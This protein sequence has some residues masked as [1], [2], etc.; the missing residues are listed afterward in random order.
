MERL[1]YLVVTLFSLSVS[2]AIA[3]D[4]IVPK[5]VTVLTEEQL[6]NKVVGNTFYNY[7]WDEYYEPGIE[8]KLEGKLTIKHRKYGLVSGAWSIKGSQFC[9]NYDKLPLSHHGDCFTFAMDGDK[10]TY[11]K[12]DGSIWHSK[13]GTIKQKMG[14]PNNF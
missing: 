14:N 12:A 7:N 1:S 10:V 13:G 11:Y 8:K 5:G 2:I 4:Y 3:Q 6:L 9:I